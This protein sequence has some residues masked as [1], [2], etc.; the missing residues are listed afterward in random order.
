MSTRPPIISSGPGTRPAESLPDGP[1][2]ALWAAAAL[3][4]LGVLLQVSL[5][6]FIRIGLGIPD[7]V[8]CTVVAVAVLR[9]PVV[10]A[11]AGFGGGLLLELSAPVGSLGV[12]ALL[13]LIAGGWAGGYCERDESFD[14]L[15]PIVLMVAAA[16]AAQ[17][18]SAG[19]QLMKGTPVFAANFTERVLVPT[20]VLTAL[21]AAPTLLLAR[22]LLGGPR[23]LEPFVRSE[24]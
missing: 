9:G 6:P 20:L 24:D 14:L 2:R 23:S 10:G 16:A 22:R 11:V 7:L 18:G 21:V 13:Y 5:M 4:V 8:A 17:L 19:V 12:L 1:G 15:P 3:I